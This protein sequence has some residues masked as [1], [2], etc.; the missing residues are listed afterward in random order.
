MAINPLNPH[1]SIENPAT[2][3]DEE[4]MTALELAGRTAAK[5]N[6]TVKAFN[7]LEEETNEHLDKQ[8]E[9]I[10]LRMGAQD[11]R[12]TEMN[13]VT[14]P[15]KVQQE[16][17]RRIEDGTFDESIDEYA[18][19][20]EARLANLLGSV[21]TGSTT[22]DAEVIDMRVDV[23]GVAYASA[24]AAMRAGQV[25]RVN[26]IE[27]DFNDLKRNMFG[28]A[29][30]S[31]PN[32]PA[33]DTAFLYV[34]EVKTAKENNP[35][36]IQRWHS[37]SK[38]LFYWRIF[39]AGTWQPWQ[40][41]RELHNILIE[42]DLNNYKDTDMRAVALN[43][44]ANHPGGNESGL[45]DVKLYQAAAGNIWV[46]QTW[47]SITTN[48]AYY[49]IWNGD[50]W[51]A[52]VPTT[53]DYNN[54]FT[55]DLNNYTA[56]N[57][58]GVVSAGTPNMPSNELGF[59]DV[60]YYGTGAAVW[61]VQTFYGA[62]SGAVF[63]RTYRGTDWTGW[64]P[65]GGGSASRL[66][67][68]TVVFMGDSIFG[69]TQD[70]TGIVKLFERMTG[71]NCHNFAFGGTRAKSRSENNGWNYFD[72]EK[73]SE[74]I[75]S[76]NFSAQTNALPTMSGAPG[77]FYNS[78]ESLKNFDFSSADYLICN[79]GTND[80]TGGHSAAHYESGIKAVIENIL[81]KYPNIVFIKCTP[82]Q[83]FIEVDGEMLPGTVYAQPDTGI[84]LKPLIEADKALEDAY[85]IQV[86]DLT[87]IGINNL[88]RPYFF[89][90][91][92]TTHQN[93]NGRRRI[94]EYLAAAIM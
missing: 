27:G 5:C 36:F 62:E 39:W 18:G 66:A 55:D 54:Y 78:L 33:N 25:S 80:W 64:F 82:T 4:A 94:A 45:L 2:I 17:T 72:G 56:G 21:T 70:A 81:G 47:T 42:T 13:E 68:K 34:D 77:Y 26:F 50:A 12:I 31:C 15:A 22:M 89:N 43:T 6:E 93:A 51:G 91:D 40:D 87:N 52:W 73:L 7:T 79:W 24:G 3:Y 59:L 84:S 76:G 11:D 8:D 23:D 37:V 90:A 19:N 92:D 53:E 46:L 16:M 83:R 1:Y 57:K 75:V 65:M 67:G 85:S 69:N 30:G 38:N 86:V 63:Y 32:A 41:G 88:T 14:M 74:S 28:V 71:A 49:R 35:N 9:T 10:E 60:T 61:T 48:S 44:A 29:L 58:R 20:L